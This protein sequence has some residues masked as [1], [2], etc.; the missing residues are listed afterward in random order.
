MIINTSGLSMDAAAKFLH[1]LDVT[2]LATQ[3]TPAVQELH[4]A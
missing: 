4:H 2:A 1:V 3:R